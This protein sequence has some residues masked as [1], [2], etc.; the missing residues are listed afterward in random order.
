[1]RA[2]ML[3]AGP[4]FD[5]IQRRPMRAEIQARIS[6]VDDYVSPAE[7]SVT[8]TTLITNYYFIDIRIDCCF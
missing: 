1:M 4:G 5:W 8:S 7:V 3:E 2:A 6:S